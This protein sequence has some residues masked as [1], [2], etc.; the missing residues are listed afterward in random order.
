MTYCYFSSTPMEQWQSKYF[1]QRQF[2][3]LRITI[4][5]QA[6]GDAQKADMGYL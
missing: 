1:K 4:N 6:L 5:T 3:L 2:D